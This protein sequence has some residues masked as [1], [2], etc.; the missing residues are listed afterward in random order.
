MTSVNY[1]KAGTR[2]LWDQKT[3]LAT[4][5]RGEVVH[6]ARRRPCCGNQSE[7]MSSKL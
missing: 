4:D 5:E 2:S 6:G 3:I 7:D 1:G